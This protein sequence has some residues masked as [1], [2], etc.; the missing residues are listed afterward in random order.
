MNTSNPRVRTPIFF[1]ILPI[2]LLGVLAYFTQFISQ[3]SSQAQSLDAQVYELRGWLWNE[4]YGFTIL[5]PPD[6]PV[7]RP[8]KEEVSRN[9]VNKNIWNPEGCLIASDP[10]CHL[11]Y[12]AGE[13]SYGVSMHRISDTEY[14]LH[15]HAWN[16]NAGWISFKNEDFGER[17]GEAHRDRSA[18]CRDTDPRARLEKVRGEWRLYGCAKVMNKK[19]PLGLESIYLGPQYFDPND[20]EPLKI[21]F[22]PS[23]MLFKGFAWGQKT[24]IW[25]FGSALP[26]LE[27]KAIGSGELNF[28]EKPENKDS[29]HCQDRPDPIPTPLGDI[30]NFKASPEVVT[31][32]KNVKV[33]WKADKDY[34]CILRKNNVKILSTGPLSGPAHVGKYRTPEL[35]VLVKADSLFILSCTGPGEATKNPDGT[36]T[37]STI[38]FLTRETAVRVL[39]TSIWDR[40]FSW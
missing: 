13:R 37:Q 10:F 17:D 33:S 27:V 15:G 4:V 16:S 6:T 5:G 34:T 25:S 1:F 8:T 28:C 2:L 36:T 31:K 14:R 18:E 35:E 7:L 3:I 39:P 32:D 26:L 30:T 9:I 11:P 24:G 22:D 12:T 21:V 29:E 38:S 19:A 40:I 20:S 23:T